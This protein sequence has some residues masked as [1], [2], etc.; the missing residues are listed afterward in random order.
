VILPS[1]KLHCHEF[2]AKDTTGCT[3][4]ANEEPGASLGSLINHNLALAVG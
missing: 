1:Q 4:S 2:K 3:H